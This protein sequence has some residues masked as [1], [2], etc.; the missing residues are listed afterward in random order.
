MC[1]PSTP[2]APKTEMRQEVTHRW[3]VTAS[4]L[5]RSSLSTGGWVGGK[6]TSPAPI[7]DITLYLIK[8]SESALNSSLISERYRKEIVRERAREILC[9]ERGERGTCAEGAM[10]GQGP[11]PRWVTPLLGVPLTPSH[12]T[13][14]QG[15]LI[16]KGNICGTFWWQPER[17]ESSIPIKCWLTSDGAW[18]WSI[19]SQVILFYVWFCTAKLHKNIQQLKLQWLQQECVPPWGI[20]IQFPPVD[21]PWSRVIQ[22]F[23]PPTPLHEG[24]QENNYSF[25]ALKMRTDKLRWKNEW[26]KYKN[27]GHTFIYWAHFQVPENINK[28][29]KR[30]CF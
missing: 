25:L 19:D 29:A 30:W 13:A 24:G 6:L 17:T 15:L 8:G 23:V 22:R 1:R 10:L 18:I 7:Y 21:W 12:S 28:I 4:S 2:R 26:G 9:V 14:S 27:S 16:Q 5:K 20:N 3:G 11:P